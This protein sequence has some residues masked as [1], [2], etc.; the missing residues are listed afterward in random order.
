MYSLGD[1]SQ[2]KALEFRYRAE[3]HVHSLIF[4]GLPI[5]KKNRPITSIVLVL[6]RVDKMLK[7]VKI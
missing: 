3:M 6:G 7:K 2:K 5:D 4:Q 1:A